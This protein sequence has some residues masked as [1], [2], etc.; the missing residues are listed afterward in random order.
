MKGLKA[1]RIKIKIG[2]LWESPVLHVLLTKEDE[3]I[4]ARCLD[5]T[6]SSHGEDEKDALKSLTDAIKEYILTAIEKSNI[7]NI[8]D[9]AHNK[10]WQMFNE[11]ETKESSRSFKKSLYKSTIMKSPE[12]L[13]ELTADLTYD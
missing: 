5:F 3:V 6:V 8:Y 11:L 2:N 7:N 12:K 13:E 9:S 1:N 4:V 10:Y